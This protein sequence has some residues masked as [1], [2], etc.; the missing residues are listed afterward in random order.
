[1]GLFSFLPVVGDVLDNI[2]NSTI[3]YNINAH[4]QNKQND[5][6][7]GMYRMQREDALADRSHMEQYNSPKIKWLFLKML[8]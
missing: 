7:L 1:M 8:D 4:Q 2:W 5:Y 6:N 3:G